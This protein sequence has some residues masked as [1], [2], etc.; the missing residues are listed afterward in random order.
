MAH[1]LPRER[2][3]RV[4]FVVVNDPSSFCKFMARCIDRFFFITRSKIE[5]RWNEALVRELWPARIPMHLRSCLR[6]SWQSEYLKITTIPTVENTGPIPNLH[7]VFCFGYQWLFSRPTLCINIIFFFITPSIS[8]RFSAKSYA[9]GVRVLIHR[10]LNLDLFNC[11]LDPAT[12]LAPAWP[13]AGATTW[14]Q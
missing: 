14:K 3:W 11:S 6:V 8:R 5:V 2:Q 13:V 9:I 10:G 7:K 4:N 1:V 12:G